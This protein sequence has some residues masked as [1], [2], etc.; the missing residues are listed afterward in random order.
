MDRY[1]S[2]PSLLLRVS[3][4][5]SLSYDYSLLKH[6]HEKVS[7]IN[8]E[9]AKN[10]SG[11]F[12]YILRD[13]YFQKGIEGLNSSD[14][15]WVT[16]KLK[17]QFVPF[18]IS[19]KVISSDSLVHVLRNLVV[20]LESKFQIT[21]DHINK[22]I[23]LYDNR[24][25]IDSL[26]I[27]ISK[28][29]LRIEELYPRE[30]STVSSNSFVFADKVHASITE[31]FITPM[32]IRYLN[33]SMP[34][35]EVI[36]LGNDLVCYQNFL[37]SE[38]QA[39]LNVDELKDLWEDS[40]FTIYRENPFDFRKIEKRILPGTQNAVLLLLQHYANMLLNAKNC[41]E[42]KLY[43]VK[44]DRLSERV[45]Y[46]IENQENDNVQ[47]LDR[48]LRRERVPTRIERILEL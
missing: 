9:V 38:K 7:L 24:E 36:S 21:S 46:L 45:N 37:I 4:S 47:Q 13:Q 41:N 28:N 20:E 26:D 39:L 12:N 31:R 18:E 17:T 35:I 43:L 40:M 8:A 27:I 2:N 5:D 23:I 42:L 48:A 6:I 1:L 14:S 15:F 33:N 16:A 34:Q 25:L 10:K 22:S 29:E 19:N 32:K 30:N 44:I 11:Y 3:S